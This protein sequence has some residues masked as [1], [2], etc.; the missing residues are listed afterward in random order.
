MF[1]EG[2][3]TSETPPPIQNLTFLLPLGSSNL[4][5]SHRQN[6]C[7]LSQIVMGCFSKILKWHIFN[8]NEVEN[9]FNFFNKIQFPQAALGCGWPGV[10]R[11]WG[12]PAGA[13]RHEAKVWAEENKGLKNRVG[14]PMII[15]HWVC[16]SIYDGLELFIT[17]SSN[18]CFYTFP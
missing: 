6:K 1:L 13:K 9:E 17:N 18:L 10:C 11:H 15:F 14:L 3:E 2:Y 16:W 4:R 12:T 8:G 5:C 7:R